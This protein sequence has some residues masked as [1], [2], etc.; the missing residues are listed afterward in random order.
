MLTNNFWKLT[1]IT[2]CIPTVNFQIRLPSLQ[3]GLPFSRWV[4]FAHR[5][6][7]SECALGAP[8]V[9]WGA[10]SELNKL[11]IQLQVQIVIIMFTT[12]ILIHNSLT[13]DSER[14]SISDGHFIL[15]VCLKS[16]A[17]K[18]SMEQHESYHQ[19]VQLMMSHGEIEVGIRHGFF[20]LISSCD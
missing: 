18:K 10:Y 15:Q 12:R 8:A 17:D 9:L 16:F 1:L 19:R 13:K 7:A 6:W 4:P 5:Y 3:V 20:I 2:F 14:W 11:S